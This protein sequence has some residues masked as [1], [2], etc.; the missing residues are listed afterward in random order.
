SGGIQQ[1]VLNWNMLVGAA[2][3]NVKRSS[4][5]GGPYTTIATGVLG[6]SYTNSP[7]PDG[8]TYY[9]IVSGNLAMAVESAYSDEASGTTKPAAPT[10]LTATAQQ[11]LA[12]GGT[13][14]QINLSWNNSNPTAGL[15][16][17]VQQSTDGTTFSQIATMPGT[18]T[19]F[20]ASNLNQLATY[21]YTVSASNAGGDS[22]TSN[23]NSAMTTLNVNFAAGVSNSAGNAVAP[24]P[25]GYLQVIGQVFADRGNGWSFA[26]GKDVLAGV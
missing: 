4:V 12:T 1:I 11:G 7:L 2:D 18:A 14:R 25:S 15:T 20:A 16:F 8:T 24:T 6:T 5:S 17:K 3:Y 26:W 21:Y 23:T 13:A 19:T 22:D 9:Y 10:A